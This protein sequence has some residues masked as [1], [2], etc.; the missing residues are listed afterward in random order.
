MSQLD[1]SPTANLNDN[2]KILHNIIETAPNKHLPSKT[3]KYNKHK[4]KKTKIDY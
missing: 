2:Y 4:H 3:V 1:N